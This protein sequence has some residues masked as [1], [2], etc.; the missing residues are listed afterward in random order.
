MTT[1]TKT[2]EILKFTIPIIVEPDGELFHSYSPALKGL[3][4]D[5]CTE[6]EALDNAK[7]TAKDFLN[8]MIRDCIPIPLSILTWKDIN[9]LPGSR[10]KETYHIE[11]ITLKI[12]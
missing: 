3:H 2:T 5:G 11:E 7:K 10:E 9:K 8:I 12:R 4:M 6:K 1:R